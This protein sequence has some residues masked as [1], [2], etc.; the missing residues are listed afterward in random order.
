MKIATVTLTR[1]GNKYLR[2]YVEYYKKL[3]VDKMYFYD[4]NHENEPKV[5]EVLKD[6]ESEGFV[7]IIP[8]DFISHEGEESTQ[9]RAYRNFYENHG[10]DFDY[11]GFVDDDE[12]LVIN[13]GK[14]IKEFFENEL[15]ENVN[16]VCFPMINFC[17][18]GVIINDKDTRLDVYTR[19]KNKTN[20]LSNSFY[21]TFIKG[22]VNASY[23][24]KSYDETGE[25]YSQ[26][27]HVPVVDNKLYNNFVDCDGNKIHTWITQVMTVNGYIKHFPT[28]CIDD[29]IN[30]KAKRGWKRPQS[31][32]HFDYNYFINYN[33]HT[34]EKYKYYIEHMQN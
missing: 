14:S 22:G 26:L 9:H 15:Y 27:Q 24:E 17:D 6:Y 13:N 3:G 19:I 4:N 8:F 21:K 25:I 16:G 34:E 31:N 30:V 1:L 28:G 2:E 32:V 18:S 10:N 7:E 12:Y 33:D 5:I 11:I 29:Y 23:Y 20:I